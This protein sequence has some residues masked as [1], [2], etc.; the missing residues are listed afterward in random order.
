MHASLLKF[1]V[2]K[3]NDWA[4]YRHDLGR[5]YPAVPLPGQ[6]SL[7]SISFVAEGAIHGVIAVIKADIIKLGE[8]YPKT[9]GSAVDELSGKIAPTIGFQFYRKLRGTISGTSI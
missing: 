7:A 6:Y 1:F 4:E 3:K 8:K 2:E 5:P 9:H